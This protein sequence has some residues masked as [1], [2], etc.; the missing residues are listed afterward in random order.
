VA[1][2][3]T[4]AAHRRAA[5]LLTLVGATVLSWA[6]VLVPAAGAP[7]WE[8]VPASLLL[9]LD[10]VALRS[11]ARRRASR[12]MARR[13]AE[14]IERIGRE[15]V[16][17]AARAAGP[18]RLRTVRPAGSSARAAATASGRSAGGRPARP[19][20]PVVAAAA[21]SR[22]GWDDRRWED[23]TGEIVGIERPNPLAAEGWAPVPVPTPTYMSKP[24]VERPKPRP[25]TPERDFADD[26][27]L[28][29][30]LARRRAVNG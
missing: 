3:A 23:E 1:V 11:A 26:L 8:A 19:A 27:D 12:A 29:A 28:D 14:R 10:L 4:V 16:A 6:L 24:V 17:E 18:A 30:V 2:A 9:A 5:V 21:T 25:W 13:R 7:V 22:P 15:R 20:V